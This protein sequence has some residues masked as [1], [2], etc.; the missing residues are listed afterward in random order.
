MIRDL[1]GLISLVQIGVLELHPWGSR[2]DDVDHPDRV[3]FDLDPDPSV[4]FER[5]VAAAQELH[6]RLD[7]LG[8]KSFL[9]TTG[10]TGLHVVVPLARRPGWA[11]VTAFAG[12]MSRNMTKDTT[13]PHNP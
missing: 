1:A 4:S 11:E 8:L 12:A 9:K 2:A 10:G 6:D 7:Q 3:I 13:G 5:V